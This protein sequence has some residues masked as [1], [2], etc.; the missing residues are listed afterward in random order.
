MLIGLPKILPEVSGEN[1]VTNCARTHTNQ[2]LLIETFAL[3]GWWEILLE[4]GEKGMLEIDIQLVDRAEILPSMKSSGAG[5]SL[6]RITAS[7]ATEMSPSCQEQWSGSVCASENSQP[8][9]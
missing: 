5:V 2:G 3:L 8:A 1:S 9:G 4:A 6:H 7:C